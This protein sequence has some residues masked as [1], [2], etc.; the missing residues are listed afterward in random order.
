[1]V[2]SLLV[3][4]VNVQTTMYFHW[5][6]LHT[7]RLILSRNSV[8]RRDVTTHRVACCCIVRTQ[9][10]VERVISYL[11]QKQPSKRYTYNL[12]NVDL[13]LQGVKTWRTT[14]W[15]AS[16]GTA[17]STPAAR[18]SRGAVLLLASY[19]DLHIRYPKNMKRNTFVLYMV[20]NRYHFASHK[21]IAFMG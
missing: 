2:T 10:D 5:G 11:V 1:M 21:Q 15:A 8:V 4:S 20:T 9:Q 13:S 7:D 17:T 14:E 19:A 6:R 16:A 12:G 3:G 18:Y